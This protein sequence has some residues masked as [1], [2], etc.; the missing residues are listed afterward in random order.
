MSGF[1]WPRTGTTKAPTWS[2]VCYEWDPLVDLS[3]VSKNA[4]YYVGEPMH[5]HFEMNRHLTG[6]GRKFGAA[7]SNGY[8]LRWDVFAAFQISES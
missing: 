8:D 6:G 2:D 4:I 3:T 7:V 1:I 5:W